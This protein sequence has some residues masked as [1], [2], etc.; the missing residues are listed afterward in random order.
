MKKFTLFF[1]F[2]L[3]A[4]ASAPPAQVSETSEVLPATPP[5]TDT[6][7]P[8]LTPTPIAVDGI[9]TIDGI[10]Y[11]F[12]EAAQ[13]WV[14]LPEL[15]AEFER[16]MVAEDGRI[17]V[18]D[19][20]GTEVYALDMETGNWLEA[21]TFEPMTLETDPSKMGVCT[22]EDIT[23]GRL[24]WSVD[25]AIKNGNIVFPEDAHNGGWE[26]RRGESNSAP[27]FL[28]EDSNNAMQIVNFCKINNEFLDMPEKTSYVASYAVINVDGTVGT[29]HFFLGSDEE[30][31]LFKELSLK[32]IGI[33]K[34]LN[35]AQAK[36]LWD[37]PVYGPFVRLYPTLGEKEIM[38]MVNEL[39]ITG[40]VSKELSRTLLIPSKK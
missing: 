12:D 2:L 28:S 16:V 10:H 37:H 26:N 36:R 13:E 18:V 20:N 23:S 7:A 33:A 19:E 21:V 9:A 25:Q 11:I 5:P 24:D 8:T 40:V 38:K 6:P 30:W 35:S 27:I 39:Q 1:F 4:C 14:A 15:N 31:N 3:T 17:V 32:E 34:Q 29:L 22:Y